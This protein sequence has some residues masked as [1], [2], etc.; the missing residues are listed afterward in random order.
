MAQ[1]SIYGGRN[2]SLPA[3][4]KIYR[5]FTYVSVILRSGCTLQYVILHVFVL[6]LHCNPSRA[7]IQFLLLTPFYHYMHT[8]LPC[9]EITSRNAKISTLDPNNFFWLRSFIPN[10]TKTLIYMYIYNPLPEFA[11]FFEQLKK[12]PIC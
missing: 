4:N 5:Y 3:K 11:P 8:N 12:N 9:T 1:N 7:S 6:R 2:L 10:L